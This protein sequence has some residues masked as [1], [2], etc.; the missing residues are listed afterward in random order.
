MPS[1]EL[2]LLMAGLLA[3]LLLLALAFSG[4][5][6]GKLV[7]RRLE[8]LRERHSRSS[9]AVAQAQLKR[10]FAQRQNRG[11]GFAKRF[12]PNPALLQLRLN[13]TGRS[14]TLAQYVVASMGLA[15]AVVAGSVVQ[16]RHP[17]AGAA[18]RPPGRP[19][20][21]ASGDQPADQAAGQQVHFQV[22]RRD[23]ADGARP[24]LGPA[25]LRDDRRGRRRAARAGQHR[26]PRGRRQDEDRP[27][28]GRGAAGDGEPARH[29]RIPV[30]RDQPR[31]P[32]RDRRQPRRDAV[33]PRRR[34]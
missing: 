12:I 24:A 16:E 28:H 23:R 7:A 26:V 20:P 15:V 29:S 14:W 18:G 9:D 33:E 32:A 17:A 10:I 13:Q 11:D 1:F 30:L 8:S 3:T 27:H 22:P 5:S 25:D 6:A 31:H 34:A 2:I 19:R 4:P 21:A